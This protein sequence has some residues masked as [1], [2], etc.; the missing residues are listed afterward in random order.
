MILGEFMAILSLQDLYFQWEAAG[1]FEFLLPA[2]LIFAVIFGV[3]STTRIMGANRGINM[4]IALSISLL[5]IRT[6]IVSQFFTELFPNFAIGLAVILAVVILAGLFIADKNA[7][8]F[9][10]TMMWAGLGIGVVV[11]IIVLNNNNWYG[12]FWW[13]ENWTSILWVVVLVLLL[14]FFLSDP[15]KKTDAERRI[16]LPVGFL[17][18]DEFPAQK[19]H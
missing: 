9:Y 1:I 3:L 8:A 11:A 4:L 13:Q 7:T 6:P 18:N 14:G 2:L 5:A 10:N 15:S 17:R 19:G 12:S 16:T